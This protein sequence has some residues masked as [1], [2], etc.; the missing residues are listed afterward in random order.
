MNVLWFTGRKFD[1]FCSTTQSSLAT[2]MIEQGH[3]VHILN[4]DEQGSHDGMKWK[5]TGFSISSIPGLQSRKLSKKMKTW[6]LQNKC[7]ADSVAIVDWRVLNHIRK[8]LESKN[9]PWIMMDRSPPA[10]TGILSLLQWPVWKRSWKLVTKSSSGGA[11]VVSTGHSDLV[12]SKVEISSDKISILPAGVDLELFS[13]SSKEE[14]L[15]LVYHGRLD[16]HRG[17]LALPMLAS[18]CI[19]AGI[20]V[21]LHLIGEGDCFNELKQLGEIHDYIEVQHSLKQEKV[22]Q[23]LSKSHI[24][25]LPMPNTKLWSI[26]SPLKRSEYAASGMLIFGINHGGHAF[27]ESQNM[28]WIKLVE[29]YDFHT[30]GIQWFKSLE[31]EIIAKMSKSARL[32]AE[33]NLS[34]KNSVDTLISSLKSQLN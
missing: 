30:D 1:N 5:H 8:A 24:G 28:D 29:Q 32:F 22:A 4:P 27:P 20:D 2:G 10:D 3:L 19:Q 7:D 14:T 23:I 25:L 17:I 31:P 26:A 15:T 13:P 12:Q 9:I 11:C 18:K 33:H 6:I 34:W 16:K 21:K